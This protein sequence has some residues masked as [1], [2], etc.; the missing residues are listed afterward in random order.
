MSA[1]YVPSLTH[2]APARKSI[3]I[4]DTATRTGQ[5]S[6]VQVVAEATIVAIQAPLKEGQHNLLGQPLP[7]GFEINGPV[8]SIR[9][10]GGRVECHESY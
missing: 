9:L 7:A 6:L 8:T 3:V 4:A 10:S 2:P 5:W 1:P